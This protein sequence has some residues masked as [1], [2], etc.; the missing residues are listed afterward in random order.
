MAEQ[1]T[2][3]PLVGGS[4]PPFAIKSLFSTGS[5]LTFIIMKIRLVVDLPVSPQYGMTR[6]RT[7]EVLGMQKETLLKFPGYFVKSDTGEIVCVFTHE[8]VLVKQIE[9]RKNTTKS[10]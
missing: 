3:K 9:K 8:A 7:F 4:N 5:F 10:K 6:G 2:H 1:G